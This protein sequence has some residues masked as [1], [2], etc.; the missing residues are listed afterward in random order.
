MVVK[1]PFGLDLDTV[2]PQQKRES[3]D[4]YWKVMSDWSSCS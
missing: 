1:S 2:D 3:D 4:G